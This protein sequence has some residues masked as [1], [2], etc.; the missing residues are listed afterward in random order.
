MALTVGSPLHESLVS[1]ALWHMALYIVD[2]QTAA[3]HDRVAH[4]P[5][6]YDSMHALLVVAI[7]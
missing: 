5:T 1:L 2:G 7:R 3:L 4:G 6:Y